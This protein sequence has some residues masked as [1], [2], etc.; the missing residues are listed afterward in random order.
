M[1]FTSTINWTNVSS[2]TDFLSIANTSTSGYFWAAMIWMV[3]LILLITMINFGFE[4]AL[5]TSSFIALVV[6]LSLVS[7]G[8]VN[9]TYT[10]FWFAG[11]I[12]FTIIYI[13]WSSN[14][15]R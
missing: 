11:M 2:V 3:W 5:L 13:V 4:V 1:P 9:P 6:S 12:L 8:L 7:V 14:R 15:D 10:I